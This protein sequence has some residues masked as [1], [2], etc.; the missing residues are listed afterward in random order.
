MYFEEVLEK[1]RK[2]AFSQADKGRKFEKL[3][4]AYLKT[5]SKF[6]NLLDKVWLWSDF[7]A[8]RN[9]SGQDTGIDL[10][11]KTY[12]GKYWAIQCKFFA[13]DGYISKSDVDTFISTS[14][15]TF[16]DEN[17]LTT[18]FSFRLWVDTTQ[19]VFSQ[20]AED[21]FLNQ[22]IPVGRLSYDDLKKSPIDWRKLDEGITGEKALTPKKNIKTSSK[23][24]RK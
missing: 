20:N 13:K 1:Y 4:Q 7:Y 11:A 12:D 3:I 15:K 8:K 24:S 18:N 14:G 23:R 2:T 5:D 22:I 19:S 6:K 17:N 10:V 21:T 16:L 9:F